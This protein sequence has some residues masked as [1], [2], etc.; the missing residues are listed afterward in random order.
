VR[1]RKE[2][3]WP[4]F[5]FCWIHTRAHFRSKGSSS[6][7]AISQ[8]RFFFTGTAQTSSPNNTIQ[9]QLSIY[10]QDGKDAGGTTA[11]VMSNEAKQHKTLLALPAN[12][13]PWAFGQTYS[14]AIYAA[15]P[16]AVS[17]ANDFYSLTILY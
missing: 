6:R 5:R 9:I 8:R 2:H 3:Q 10:D 1:A 14:F 17:D 13:K 16:G 12:Q 11:V 15:S 4:A 7:R